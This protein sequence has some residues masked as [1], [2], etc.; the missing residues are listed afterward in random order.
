MKTIAR[1]PLSINGSPVVRVVASRRLSVYFTKS[2]HFH[3]GPR[4]KG[5][6]LLPVEP[7]RSNYYD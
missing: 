1:F 4:C 7:N 6:L 3:F 5:G 2:R